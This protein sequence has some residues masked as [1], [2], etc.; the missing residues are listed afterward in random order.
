MKKVLITG[1]NSYIGVSFENWAR[2]HYGDQLSVDTVDMMDKSWKSKDF[3]KYDIIF[4]VAGLAHVDVGKVDADTKKHYDDVNTKL[5]M[6]AAQKAKNEG[7]R[8]FVF[9]SFPKVNLELSEE[10][11]ETERGEGGFGSTGK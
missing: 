5:A 2:T 9:M 6:E 11:S 1:A 7:V 8:Q 10:L 3:S 4:H